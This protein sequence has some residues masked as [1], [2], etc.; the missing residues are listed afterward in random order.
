[1]R[2]REA[3]PHSR[4]SGPVGSSTSPRCPQSTDHRARQG[5][6]SDAN[7]GTSRRGSHG[8]YVLQRERLAA[9][10]QCQPGEAA[11]VPASSSARDPSIHRLVHITNGFLYAWR[12]HSSTVR[13]QLHN[14]STRG[15]RR[16]GVRVL[17]TSGVRRSGEFL[18]ARTRETQ[19]WAGACTAGVVCCRIVA[20]PGL[21]RWSGPK[22]GI[23]GPKWMHRP[24]VASDG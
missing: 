15:K 4:L 6:T 11:R 24:V 21:G 8:C 16:L 12:S 20:E 17:R 1:M 10:G 2:S 7:T 19:R 14:L 5:R 13:P 3:R 23:A 18:G 22:A 9:L